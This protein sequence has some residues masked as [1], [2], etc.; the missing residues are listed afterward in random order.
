[1]GSM[2]GLG[3]NVMRG[4]DSAGPR[5]S[6]VLALALAAG[7]ACAQDCDNDGVQDAQQTYRWKATGPGFWGSASSW[8]SA[9]G[10]IPG[11]ASL[12]LFDGTDGLGQQPYRPFFDGFVGVSGLGVQNSTAE[13][14]L[15]SSV[16][17]VTGD[18][19]DCREFLLGGVLGA[20]MLVFGG[21]QFRVQRAVLADQPGT[22]ARL[23]M[24]GSNSPIQLRHLDPAP[25]IV[26]QYGT[27]AIEL[28]DAEFVHFGP[29]VFGSRSG[30]DGSLSLFG[31]SELL[32]SAETASDVI[33]GFAGSGFIGLEQ[34]GVLLGN[35]PISF[36]LGDRAT[37]DGEIRF[38]GL[39]GSQQFLTS[40]LEIGG[41][42][43]GRFRVLGGS[44]V[45]TQVG[46]A[47]VLGASRGS[48]GE[49]DVL[50][51]SHL[52]IDGVP[53]EVGRLGQ[54]EV[55][56]GEG[57]VLEAP[58]GVTAYV[59]GVVQGSGDVVGDLR[60]IGG[61]I[62]PN[63]M[64]AE[65]GAFQRLRVAG[66]LVFNGTNPQTGEF[67]TGRMVY[68]LVS[69]NPAFSIPA[70][71]A[72][73]ATLDG[74]LRVIVPS[75][76]SPEVGEK[77]RVINAASLI[78]TFDAV[79]TEVL[80]GKAFAVPVYSQSD[81]DVFVEFFDVGVP[82]SALGF[83]QTSAPAG[84]LVDGVVRDVT[85]D[86]LPDLVV[87]ADE[88]PG[89]AGVIRVAR[90]LGVQTNGQWLGFDQNIDAYS[91]LG[92]QPGS[93]VV[94]DMNGDQLDDIVVM[95][96]GPSD[97]QIRI[98]LNSATQPGDFSQVDPREISVNGVPADITL[99]DVN[100][101]GLLDVVSVFQRGT[102]GGG[103]GIGVAENDGGGFDDS[104]GDTGDD[105]GSVDSMGGEYSATGF[106]TTSKSEASVSIF[107]GTASAGLNA[108]RGGPI[109]PLFF[110]QE[111][112][113]GR[114]PDA[115]FTAD[116]NGDGLDDVIAADRESGTISVLIAQDFGEI[117]YADAISLDAGEAPFAAQP[118][119]VV[120]IDIN[121]DDRLDL[122]FTARDAQG[123]VGLRSILNIAEGDAG[124]LIFGRSL[125]L[126]DDGA[127]P[128]V[129]A[130]ADLDGNGTDDLV[131]VREPN[132][133]PAVSTFLAPG[134][135]PCNAADISVPFG[136]LD[137]N[138]IGVF[139][140]AFVN[141]TPAADIAPPFGVY[142]LA[143]INVF[144]SAFVT[145]C[146]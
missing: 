118:G 40:L 46:T 109:F 25:M 102:R 143:D 146:P 60:L 114:E 103:G 121:E 122:V 98:R 52:G 59:D 92:D 8:Q 10:G 74:T 19:A 75:G 93:V 61:E 132:G 62:R 139:I 4:Y 136:V 53:V 71:V 43:E 7:A 144:V 51:F 107:G 124:E 23:V 31:T 65:T 78:G 79:Q 21:G 72:S 101:N 55:S 84:D 88:G 1:M 32:L 36:R 128:R 120:A 47:A 129:L 11:T 28:F 63:D 126:P 90:N 83:S 12:A 97:G 57:S 38:S 110:L 80:G 113:A 141:Q 94:G 33:V 99:A 116:M 20:D 70:E 85:G 26:G 125:P 117:V 13:F 17:S 50:N 29:L 64:F 145:G 69:R 123:Q 27:G 30:S 48:R 42:G 100:G 15:G 95:N 134:P 22:T 58:D 73:S 104:E 127:P 142:D 54:G 133:G 86:G 111:V 14:D 96:R 77:Y 76:V 131:V 45:E 9:T 18:L 135:G 49:I 67:E 87:I 108:N 105:P 68:T 81:G 130:V 66:K 39:L 137:L 41:Q 89:Q 2:T 138:D 34:E 6:A 44:V 3:V 91:S 119:S 106:A 37:G 115:M 35:G 5:C 16:L 24:D 140:S 112:P 82:D 56:V